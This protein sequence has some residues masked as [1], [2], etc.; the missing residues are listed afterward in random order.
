LRRS[1]ASIALINSAGIIDWVFSSITGAGGWV[2]ANQTIRNKCQN[3]VKMMTSLLARFGRKNGF[4][5]ALVREEVWVLPVVLH[6]F[7][8]CE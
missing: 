8:R 6:N 2:V 4:G 5:V 1:Q 7:S 3:L